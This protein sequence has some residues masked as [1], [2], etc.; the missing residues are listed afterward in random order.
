MLE[1]ID[2]IRRACGRILEVESRC[3]GASR[4]LEAPSSI[5]SQRR[6]FRNLITEIGSGC[7]GA[8]AHCYLIPQCKRLVRIDDDNSGEGSQK[9]ELG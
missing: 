5:V 4:T 8:L 9:F 2:K 6:S 7:I 1:G 3:E